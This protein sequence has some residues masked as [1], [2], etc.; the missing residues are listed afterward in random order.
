M[1]YNVL[2]LGS[3]GREHALAWKISRSFVLGKFYALPGNPGINSLAEGVDGSV[4]DFDLILR[5]VVEKDIDIVVCGPEDPLVNGLKDFLMSSPE[6]RK[7]LLFVGPGRDGAALEGSKD[8]A[9]EFMARHGIP[10]AAY[11]TFTSDMKDEAYAFLRTLRPPYVVK[12]DGLAAGK[13]VIIS[14]TLKEAEESLDHIFGGQFGAAG[15]KVVIEEYLDGVEVSFFA[16]TD[17]H[18]YLLLPE[19]KDYK[20]VG[21]GDTGL[22]TGGMGSVSPVPFCTPEFVD[23]VRNRIIEPTVRGLESE[24]MDYRGFIFFGL[25]NCGGDPYVIEYNV[26]MGDP[27]TESVMLRI[28]SDLLAHMAA[29]ARGDLSQERIQ[30]SDKSAVTCIVVSGGYPGKYAKG[31]EITGIDGLDGL[32]VFHAG[33]AVRDGRLVTSGGRVLAVAATAYDMGAAREEVYSGIDRVSFEGAAHRS[34][35]AV[36]MIN[37]PAGR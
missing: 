30:V 13:G 29:A 6:V 14:P 31:C 25:M 34:D 2:L 8:F 7:D 15:A 9:K 3:G 16:L 26:R 12:A 17:G 18:R 4:G 19:A 24:G 36:D 11:R 28:D 33:T 22:N 1:K 21:D 20:R 10:T 5:T 23:K 35:I 32:T 27:E 37:W